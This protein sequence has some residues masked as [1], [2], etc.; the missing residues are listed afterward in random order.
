MINLYFIE[1]VA[2]S[3]PKKETKQKRERE[4]KREKQRNREREKTENYAEQ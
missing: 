2:P 3:F 1:F 4:R